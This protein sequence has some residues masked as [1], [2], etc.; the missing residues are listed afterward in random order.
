MRAEK[1][2]HELSQKWAA[3]GKKESANIV[4]Q[5]F[6]ALGVLQWGHDLH[7]FS[8]NGTENIEALTV[9]TSNMGT[10]FLGNHHHVDASQP[11][12]W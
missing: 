2:L 4:D 1:N 3:K 9:Y 12:G 8:S 10:S 7:R 5:I 11:H 6:N